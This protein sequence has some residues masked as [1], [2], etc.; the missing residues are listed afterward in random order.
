MIRAPKFYGKVEQGKLKLDLREKFHELIQSLE[1]KRIEIVL[2]EKTAE[3]SDQQSRYYFGVVVAM[4]ADYV[5]H[6]KDEMHSILKEKFHIKTTTTLKANEFQD[7]ISKVIRF[8]AT[9]LELNI[10]DPDS[11]EY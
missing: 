9:D 3:R 4:I 5:G 2:K 10:P 6:T 11:V 7:Y 1:G 8:A